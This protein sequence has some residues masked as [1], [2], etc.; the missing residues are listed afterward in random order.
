M[1]RREL[2]T[3]EVIDSA[4]SVALSQPVSGPPTVHAGTDEGVWSLTRVPDGDIDGPPDATEDLAPNA[5]DGNADSI[6]DRLQPLRQRLLADRLDD[7]LRLCGRR[8]LGRPGHGHG[9]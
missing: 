7:H 3:D 5:G 2:F 9:H 6:A 8:R 1:L 4:Q